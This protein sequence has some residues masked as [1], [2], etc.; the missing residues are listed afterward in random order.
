MQEPA[1]VQGFARLLG[2]LDLLAQ[3][4]IAGAVREEPAL[5]QPGAAADADRPGR[6]ASR[7]S[8]S[9]RR[10]GR[11]EHRVLGDDHRLIPVAR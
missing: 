4:V 1:S 10:A 11:D 5:R 9:G 6:Q 8:Q 2:R 7:G 3:L